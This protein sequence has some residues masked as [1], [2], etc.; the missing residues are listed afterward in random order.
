MRILGTVLACAFLVWSCSKTDQSVKISP[1]WEVSGVVVDRDR[2]DGRPLVLV[3]DE[4]PGV[5][6]SC[7][8]G[9]T[10]AG[11]KI[12]PPLAKHFPITDCLE[13]V[14]K[15]ASVA[16]D[17]ESIA[18]IKPGEYLILSESLR[19]LIVGHGE[20]NSPTKSVSSAGQLKVQYYNTFGEIGGRGLEGLAIRVNNEKPSN[21]DVAALW[22]G[23][24]PEEKRMVE[25]LGEITL[26]ELSTCKQKDLINFYRKDL[27]PV[28][29]TFTSDLELNNNKVL[30]VKTK[31]PSDLG[32]ETRIHVPAPATR[33]KPDDLATQRFRAPDL[34]WSKPQG[35][36]N[37]DPSEIIST[38]IVLISS[39]SVPKMIGG[40][41]KYDY[42]CLLEIA[43]NGE[44][45]GAS[46][47]IKAL[48]DAHKLGSLREFANWEGLAWYNEDRLI[49]VNDNINDPNGPAWEQIPLTALVV[50]GPGSWARHGKPCIALQ[51]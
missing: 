30:D 37:S 4:S 31:K 34:V 28:L 19:A 47:D 25:Q 38:Y 16:T 40:N 35:E 9:E 21:F 6:F 17:F 11:L 39:S 36:K 43:E 7:K 2:K 46:L 20:T 33:L 15:N 42:A 41:E 51:P 27:K 49:L 14:I 12:K 8:D 44:P 50:D 29:V 13:N 48:L 26:C 23:G 22:E 1:P 18:I 32:R 3:A 24:Y 10:P 5:Y 45:T